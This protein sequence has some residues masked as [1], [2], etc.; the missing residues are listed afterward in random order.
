MRVFVSVALLAFL[1]VATLGVYLSSA[2]PD[3]HGAGCPLMVGQATLCI[4]SPLAHLDHWQDVFVAVIVNTFALFGLVILTIV[5][6]P[7]RLPDK[8]RARVDSR[9]PGPDLPPLFQELFSQGIL[10]P[11]AP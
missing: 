4:G 5:V 8:R 1:T 9:P 2:A 7:F 6:L 3:H 11:K 10:H